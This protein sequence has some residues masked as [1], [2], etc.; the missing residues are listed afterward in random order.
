[1]PPMVAS[2]VAGHEASVGVAHGSCCPW[3]LLLLQG[4]R[5][6]VV[7]AHGLS[8][9]GSQALEHRFNSCGAQVWQ[10]CGMGDLPRSGIELMSPALAGGLPLSQGSPELEF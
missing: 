9:C 4:T 8:S 5:L 10:L 6:S 3:W 2:L 1:M 7:A